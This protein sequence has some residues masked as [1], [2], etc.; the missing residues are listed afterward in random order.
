MTYEVHAKADWFLRITSIVIVLLLV[1]V[2]SLQAAS[3]S[4]VVVRGTDGTVTIVSTA[5]ATTT[6]Y[7]TTTSLSYSTTTYQ[8]SPSILSES[9]V[10]LPP[11]T[12][13]HWASYNFTLQRFYNTVTLNYRIYYQNGSAGAIATYKVGS[14]NGNLNG[15]GS[16]DIQPDLAQG[17]AF[18]ISF[19]TN[20]EAATYLDFSIVGS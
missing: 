9:D 18:T 12:A 1:I 15:Q 19:A 6:V 14:A 2:V 5:Y 20:A 11:I 13:A 7:L 4:T 17:S 8:Q 10:L 16:L 3:G